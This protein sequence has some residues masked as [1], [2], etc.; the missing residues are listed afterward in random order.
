MIRFSSPLL[1]VLCLTF[2]FGTFTVPKPTQAFFGGPVAVVSDT[3]ATGI[4]TAVESTLATIAEQASTIS[5]AGLLNKEVTLDAIGFSLARTAVQQIVSE[6]LTWINAGFNGSP[7]FVTD[8]SGFLVGISDAVV[9]EYIYDSDLGFICSP[10]ELDIKIALE[11]QYNARAGD[12]QPQCTLTEATENIE[13]FINGA[14]NE[15][16]WDAW[17]ELT[18][19]ST[20]D[21]NKAYYE[22]KL[23][24]D[25][26]IRDAQGQA[27]TELDW[28]DGLLSFK[29]CSDSQ[30]QAGTETKC[31]IVTPGMAIS[32]QLNQALGVPVD[33]LITADEINELIGAT[34]AQLGEQLLNK[35]LSSLAASNNPEDNVYGESETLSFVDALAEEDTELALNTIQLDGA[36]IAAAITAEEVNLT[37]QIEI[38]NRTRDALADFQSASSTV[39][40]IINSGRDTVNTCDLEAA[41]SKFEKDTGIDLLRNIEE[42]LDDS[43]NAKNI[44]IP[45]NLSALYDLQ[46]MYANATTT[47]A[48][49]DAAQV[50]GNYLSGGG[51]NAASSLAQAEIIL[52][53]R[54]IPEI[55]ELQNIADKEILDCRRD[56]N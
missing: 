17:F 48:I 56:S 31:T 40:G 11:T 52:Q 27:I 2:V 50:Y 14:F 13:N 38:Y 18:Q 10:F 12:Y 37:M 41:M 26:A 42:Y 23:T 53:Y 45:A 29:V 44:T 6:T 39:A 9:G 24:I 35:G 25:A 16:G 47:E 8:V 22:A 49:Y 55:E 19:G 43:L 5:L 7:A 34:L 20:N 28:G 46:I 33:S 36:A 32:E 3:S 1:F 15:G 4:K 30:V 51:S 54:I 21:P